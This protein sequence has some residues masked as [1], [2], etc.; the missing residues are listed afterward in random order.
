MKKKLV[1][2]ISFALALVMAMTSLPV[3]AVTVSKAAE[4]QALETAEAKAEKE[5]TKI[6]ALSHSTI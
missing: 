5:E 1:S 6:A 4:T 2:L 3:G